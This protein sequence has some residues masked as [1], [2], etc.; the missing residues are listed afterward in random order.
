MIEPGPPGPC[1]SQARPV[2]RKLAGARLIV[3]A[4][5]AMLGM[6]LPEGTTDD[7][8]TTRKRQALRPGRLVPPPSCCG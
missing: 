2:R 5:T 4:T 3:A 8:E 7:E 1:C 6:A